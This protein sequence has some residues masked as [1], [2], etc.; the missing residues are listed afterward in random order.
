MVGRRGFLKALGIGAAAAV[1]TPVARKI[2][3]AEESVVAS[4]ILSSQIPI[5]VAESKKDIQSKQIKD[6]LLKE[7]IDRENLDLVWGEDTRMMAHYFSSQKEECPACDPNAFMTYQ[8]MGGHNEIIRQSNH[9]YYC[10]KCNGTGKVPIDQYNGPQLKAD[11]SLQDLR[12]AF[13]DIW[14]LNTKGTVMSY[15]NIDHDIKLVKRQIKNEAPAGILLQDVVSRSSLHY[16]DRVSCGSKVHIVQRGMLIASVRGNVI[17]GDS[18]YSH[19]GELSSYDN[20][21]SGS[22]KVGTALSEKD[23]DGFAKISFS[24]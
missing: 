8:T 6:I 16:N 18:L 14:E 1:A 22:R 7:G 15:R 11:R 5:P 3:Q 9:T 2:T 12:T 20:A 10:K 13:T 4:K 23:I 21:P 24:F 19:D 17:V